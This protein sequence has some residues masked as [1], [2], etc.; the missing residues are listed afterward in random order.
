MASNISVSHITYHCIANSIYGF[1]IQFYK[2]Q[3]ISNLIQTR[4]KTKDP[5][6]GKDC[7]KFGWKKYIQIVSGNKI[8][9]NNYYY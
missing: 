3:L 1:W 7:K 2:Q 8:N 5:N 4:D 6:A 9:Y